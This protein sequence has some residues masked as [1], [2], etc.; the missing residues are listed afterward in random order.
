MRLRDCGIT[1]TFSRPRFF[2]TAWKSFPGGFTPDTSRGR[3]LLIAIPAWFSN[4]LVVIG[5]VW[6]YC[7]LPGRSWCDSIRF[8][9]TFALTTAFFALDMHLFQPRYLGIFPRLL[10]P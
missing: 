5:C 10:H 7:R 9:I 2:I 6:G 4:L 3:T 8:V 1:Q